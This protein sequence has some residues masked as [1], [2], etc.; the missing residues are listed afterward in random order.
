MALA[1]AV[2]DAACVVLVA[3]A[4]PVVAVLLVGIPVT[5][6]VLVLVAE[7]TG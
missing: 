7:A 2:G 4:T 1:A 3:D 5:P 6:A